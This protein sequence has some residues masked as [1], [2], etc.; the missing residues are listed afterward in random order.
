MPYRTDFDWTNVNT[1]NVAKTILARTVVTWIHI[2]LYDRSCQDPISSSC[3]RVT[4]TIV[5]RTDVT[6]VNCRRIDTNLY[7]K[8][9][10]EP[11]STL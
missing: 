3:V 4:G 9:G 5:E 8:C 6:W 7:Y 11:I 10:Q 1:T 2:N